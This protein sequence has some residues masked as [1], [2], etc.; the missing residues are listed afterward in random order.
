MKDLPRARPGDIAQEQDISL[1]TSTEVKGPEGEQEEAGG[2]EVIVICQLTSSSTL[3]V[4]L[5]SDKVWEALKPRPPRINDYNLKTYLRG[6]KE[7]F[8][9]YIQDTNTFQGRCKKPQGT[10]AARSHHRLKKCADRE[11]PI[12]YKVCSKNLYCTD[13]DFTIL[14]Q[15]WHH[16]S[17][18]ASVTPDKG[19]AKDQFYCP[20]PAPLRD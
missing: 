7:G 8:L 20:R 17:R 3:G 12:W 9:I 14:C 10:L 19:M 13:G 2:G 18:C 4:T 16:D 15:A 6:Y 1:D 5:S 11:I